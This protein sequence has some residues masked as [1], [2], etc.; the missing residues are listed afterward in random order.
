MTLVKIL[1]ETFPELGEAVLDTP[2]RTLLPQINFTLIDR[3]RSEHGTVRDLLAHRM[4]IPRDDL[5]LIGEPFNTTEE[6]I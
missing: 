1:H 2:I 4:C 3:F 5:Q 6:I